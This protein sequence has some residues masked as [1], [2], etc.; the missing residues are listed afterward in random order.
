MSKNDVG[1]CVKQTESRTDILNR[2]PVFDSK[3]IKE[4][5]EYFSLI[6]NLKIKASPVFGIN[7]VEKLPIRK[8][9]T[10]TGVCI[11]VR[12]HKD[13][14]LIYIKIK[15][16]TFD[17]ICKIL[18]HELY[19]AFESN[20]SSD[21]YIPRERDYSKYRNCP[22]ERLARLHTELYWEAIKSFLENKSIDENS[23]QY[24]P[25]CYDNFWWCVNFPSEL[26]REPTLREK[27]ALS[28]TWKIYRHK[29]YK[30]YS[31]IDKSKL[32]EEFILVPINDHLDSSVLPDYLNDFNAMKRL[33]VSLNATQ[34]KMFNQLVHKELSDDNNSTGPRKIFDKLTSKGI[35]GVDYVDILTGPNNFYLETYL[36]VINNT[37]R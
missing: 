16:T 1:T 3:T 37:K 23:V 30:S 6:T 5:C 31:W 9:E 11:P 34:R 21:S 10:S 25:F 33:L 2:L 20:L 8:E 26:K 14:Y 12:H 35:G 22:S 4:L 19:H 18:T 24:V 27:I 17:N 29:V 36:E 13:G 28:T 7:L 15:D 32:G